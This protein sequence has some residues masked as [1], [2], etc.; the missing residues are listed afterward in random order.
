MYI[1][2]LLVG[3]IETNCYIVNDEKH[4]TVIIDPGDNGDIILQYIEREGLMPKAILLTHAHYDHIGACDLLRDKFAIPIV[5]CEGEEPVIESTAYNLS[6]EFD[7][8]YSSKY[9]RVLNDGE[10]YKVGDLT[11]KTIHTPGH[12]PGSA[13]YYMENEKVL[14]S[15]DTLFFASIGRTDFPLSS[16]RDM[17]SSLEKLKILDVN[18]KVYPG[19]GQS[20]TIKF[21]LANNPYLS[22]E[23]FI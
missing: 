14:F 3:S 5:L 10:V 23:G 9:D 15:G 1:K 11:F 19:H 2:N 6:L 20:T 18:T 22:E 4:N 7:E 17:L 13:C 21:E 12:T 16:T 8:S